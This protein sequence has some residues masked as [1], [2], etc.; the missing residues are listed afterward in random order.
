MEKGL[1]INCQGENSCVLPRRFPIHECEEF[2]S[3]G[4]F[5]KLKMKRAKGKR[6]SS[7]EETVA[8]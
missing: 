8:E 2:S 6:H 4:F 1:C 5:A 3:N 7:Q